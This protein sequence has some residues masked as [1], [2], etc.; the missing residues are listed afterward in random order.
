M[1]DN[2]IL[3]NLNY[4]SANSKASGLISGRIRIPTEVTPI[5][6]QYVAINTTSE[7]GM[8]GSAILKSP[9][10]KK[11]TNSAAKDGLPRLVVASGRTEEAVDTIF[12][13]VR[14]I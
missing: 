7:S 13:Y 11:T 8:F 6:G 12:T 1:E 4:K 5:K 14:L 9:N 10:I 3:P 2:K